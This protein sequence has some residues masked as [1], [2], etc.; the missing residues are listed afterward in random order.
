MLAIRK[1]S[2]KSS[3]R[4]RNE[5]FLLVSNQYRSDI[6]QPPTRTPVEKVALRVRIYCN[7]CGRASISG[8][9]LAALNFPRHTRGHKIKTLERV[10]NQWIRPGSSTILRLPL[11]KC[12]LPITP[13]RFPFA[14]RRATAATRTL[15]KSR[16]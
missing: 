3:R 14:G 4:V 2:V 12:K 6:R 13:K 11:E 5:C 15:S 9:N 10:N 8:R 1:R 7:R 16:V